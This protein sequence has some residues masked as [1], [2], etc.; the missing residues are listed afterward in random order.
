[1]FQLHLV[2]WCVMVQLVEEWLVSTTVGKLV[3]KIIYLKDYN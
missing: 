1:M 2:K 3:Q